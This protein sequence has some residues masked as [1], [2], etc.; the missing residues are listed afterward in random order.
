MRIWTAHLRANAAPVLV[1]E[2]FS[3]GAFLLGPIWLLARGAL[4]PAALALAIA[5]LVGLLTSGGSRIAL[6]LGIALLLGV[7]GRDLVRWHLELRGYRTAHVLA[8]RD[9]DAALARLL[10]VR[11]DLAGSFMPPERA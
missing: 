9:E 4:I 1:P 10:A 6:E 2:G 11:P 7:S 5:L 8:A 3:V